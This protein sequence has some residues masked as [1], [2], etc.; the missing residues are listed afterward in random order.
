[1]EACESFDFEG[2]HPDIVVTQV[3]FDG[4]NTAMTVHEFF[5]SSNLKQFTD[6]LIYV[7]CFNP[8]APIDENDKAITAIRMLVE[9]PVVINSDRVVVGSEKVRDVYYKRAIELCGNET[10][11]YWQQKI[12]TMDDYFGDASYDGQTIVH[13]V[14]SADG[15][16]VIPCEQCNEKWKALVGDTS[17]KKVVLYYVSMSFLLQYREQAL[18]KISRTLHTFSKAGEDIVVIIEP[19]EAV[20][21]ELSGIDEDLDDR[22]SEL[23]VKAAGASNIVVDTNGVAL[24]HVDQCAAFYGDRGALHKKCLEVKIPVMIQN[25][26]C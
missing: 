8:D 3:P 1:V 6:E 26:E 15:G 9:Q 20:L 24:F 2:I 13:S 11:M 14:C 25:V 7:P 12:V 21:T 23:L 18:D 16:H 19:Q 4:F 17:D 10:E 5:Y 22:L